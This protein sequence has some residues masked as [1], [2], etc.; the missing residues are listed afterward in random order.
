MNTQMTTAELLSCLRQMDVKL[1]VTGDRIRFSAPPGAISPSLQTE[2]AQRKPEILKFLQEVAVVSS[3]GDTIQ[4]LPRPV[5]IPLSF[6]Q[7]RLWFLNQLDPGLPT[8]NIP[9][10]FHLS[11][12]LN[13]DALSHALNEIMRRHEVL[14]T[15]FPEVQGQPFQEINPAEPVQLQIVDV[16][17]LSGDER[18]AEISRLGREESRRAFDLARDPM[19]RAMLLKLNENEHILALTI[20]HIAA[21]GW[22]LSLIKQELSALY[23]AFTSDA[24]PALPKLPIQYADYALWQQKRMS[25]HAIQN[26]MEYWKKKLAGP[27]PVLELT[28][29][30]PRPMVQTYDGANQ[31]LQLSLAL[32]EKLKELS[33][34]ENAT[35]FMTLVAAFKTLLHRYTGQDDILLGSPVA[36]RDRTETERLI[37]FFVNTIVMR[38]DVS[39]D[40]TFRELLRRVRETAVGAFAHQDTP[41]EKL[42]AELQTERSRNHTPLFQVAFSLQSGLQERFNLQGLRA[43]RF[44][45]EYGTAKFDL[46]LFMLETAQGLKAVFEY[47]TDLF[48]ASTI[49]RMLGHFHALLGSI[50]ENP[51]SRISKLEMLTAAER[52]QIL[53][54]W[55]KTQTDYPS[56]K[57]IQELFEDQAALTPESVA[58]VFNEQQITY[59]ELNRRANR[60][61]AFLKSRD[62]S[63]GGF[64]GLCMD[65]SIDL[66]VAILGILKAGGA[67]VPLDPTYPKERLLF[68][69]ENA[70]VKTIVGQKKLLQELPEHDGAID[71]EQEWPAIARESDQ[72]IGKIS[73]PDD[74]AY[75][76]Y[77]SGSTGRPKGVT[78]PHRGV[79]RLVRNTNYASFEPSE[80]FLL[81]AP[82][83]FDASTLEIWGPLLNGG[84]LIVP[85]PGP[86]ALRDIADAIA[87]H[88]VTTLWLTAG[89]FHLMVDTRIEDL[90]YLRQLLAGGDVLSVAHVKRVLEHAPN[91]RMINCYGPTENTTFTTC[92]TVKAVER[93]DESV[94]IGRPINNTQLYILDKYLQPVPVGVPGEMY[95][96]GDGLALGY[97]NQPELT[98]EK[99]VTLSLPETGTLRAYR[100]GDRVRYLPDGNI[101]FLG[102]I[103]FQVKIRGF[104]IEPEE[105]AATLNQHPAIGESVVLVYQKDTDKRLDAYFIPKPGVSA[106]TDELKRF[107]GEKLPAWMI[108]STF[109]QME[110]FPLNANGKIDRPA[111]PVPVIGRRDTNE[112]LVLISPL[113]AELI[114]I[115]ESLLN[116]RPIGTRDDFFELGGH[117]LLAARMMAQVESLFSKKIPL[118]SLFASPTIEAL[119]QT[120]L[121]QTGGGFEQPLIEVKRGS[122]KPFFFLHGDLL[123]G[124]LYCWNLAR[125]LDAEQTFY[126]IPPQGLEGQE[127]LPAVEAMADY[128]LQ[129][130]RA[131]QPH[132]PYSLGGTCNGAMVAFEIA[133]RLR[134][135]GEKVDALILVDGSAGNV[136]FS[137]LHRIVSLIAR[138][139]GMS[140]NQRENYFRRWRSRSINFSEFRN[141]PWRQ[142]FEQFIPRVKEMLTRTAVQRPA[143]IRP[144]GSSGAPTLEARHLAMNKY[145]RLLEGYVPRY[146][147]GRADLLLSS[148]HYDNGADDREFWW[149]KIVKDL[150]VREIPGEHATFTSKNLPVLAGYI[151]EILPENLM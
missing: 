37:G 47:R 102:R 103:D 129:S 82:I 52:R 65:R 99:F 113:E 58:L 23:N 131:A 32:T 115:W 63:R 121:E 7:Q 41:F 76:M 57:S 71:I 83:A 22:S 106:A 107:L 147:A 136:Y 51:T 91:C 128:H 24:S 84:K 19:L 54:D 31:S 146:Y 72:N 20:H 70:Q 134:A 144:P 1:S 123:G 137:R 44:S 117:S 130:I 12:T 95:I 78:V 94:S 2:L 69:I 60:L 124:G 79:V 16:S 108:P 39:G 56:G 114:Q 9:D 100:T 18:Q 86:L 122:R 43:Q 141:L 15:T 67:Y 6:S 74:P 68:I 81:G 11:G 109:T 96:S 38:T 50:V 132:G 3:T 88:K 26:G 33:L 21:D 133:Q 13:V 36:G 118:S 119:A 101:E 5:Q 35:L 142:Q 25:G 127:F 64:V 138:L 116:T 75:V 66:I 151:K 30:F 77:T 92:H 62:V 87:L 89:L 135:K 85:R 143:S 98:N 40:P 139:R 46:S 28:G 111:L 80:V 148:V 120:I 17:H 34:S 27:L 105:I 59:L 104:R 4:H 53:V 73:G 112:P 97:L 14:R 110:A 8:Y 48:K 29:D 49:D 140:L 125:H 55:N 10:A 149:R 61:A 42:A 93:L 45:F 126:A 150:R 90:N 145:Q